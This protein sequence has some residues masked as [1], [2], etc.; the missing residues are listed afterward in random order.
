M[1]MMKKKK[2]RG[3]GQI[4]VSGNDRGL[5]H[6]DDQQNRSSAKLLNARTE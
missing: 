4:S 3:E 2:G 6:A 5:D 1:Q